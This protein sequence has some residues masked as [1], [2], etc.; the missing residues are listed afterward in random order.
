V[1]YAAD[2][3]LTLAVEVPVVVVV[4]RAVGLGR[5]PAIGAALLANLLT[6][7][8]LWFV[9]APWMH[10]RWGLAGVCIAELGV[11]L[12]EA[13]VYTRRFGS[14]AGSWL[15]SWLALLANA[16]SWGIGIVVHRSLD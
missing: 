10:D 12:V 6:H 5:R 2:L 4:A 8:L 13:A 15:A 3:G 7:P 9:A 16:L 11:V 14:V 1:S